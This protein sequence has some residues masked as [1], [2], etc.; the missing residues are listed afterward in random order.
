M[1]FAYFLYANQQ[2]EKTF[3]TVYQQAFS[4]WKWRQ[5]DTETS[6]FPACIVF[7]LFL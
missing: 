3:L 5:D 2:P 4:T 7:N 1:T 6:F